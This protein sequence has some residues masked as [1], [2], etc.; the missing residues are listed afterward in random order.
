MPGPL[1][2]PTEVP[3]PRD[4]RGVRHTLAVVL[5]LTACAVPTGARSL[6]AADDLRQAA[7]P[8]TRQPIRHHALHAR[9]P[10]TP[11]RCRTW[12][13]GTDGKVYGGEGS[14]RG[15]MAWIGHGCP[16]PTTRRARRTTRHLPAREDHVRRGEGDPGG[17]SRRGGR[18]RRP[19]VPGPRHR[20]CATRPGLTSQ[21]G[22]CCATADTTGA[23]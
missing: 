19:A 14:V 21:V 17:R 3:D 10:T 20:P 7:P 12:P 22:Q 6:P 13:A 4:P 1:E 15:S 11:G 9:R 5:A 16:S 2:R 8:G 23:L 18:D